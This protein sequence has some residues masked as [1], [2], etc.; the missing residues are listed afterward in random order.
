MSVV[1]DGEESDLALVHS[2]VPQGTALGPLLFFIYI[3]D[4]TSQVSSGTC[5][6]LFADDYLVYREINSTQDQVVLQQDLLRLQA[7]AELWCM[8]FNPSK[9]FILYFARK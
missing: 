7:W 8:R 1:V 4:M 2:G 6:C 3:N 5:I 9:C